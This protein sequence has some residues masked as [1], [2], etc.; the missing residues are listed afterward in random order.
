MTGII[1]AMDEEVAAL[2]EKMQDVTVTEKA[3]MEI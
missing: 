3:K 1:G 2:Q